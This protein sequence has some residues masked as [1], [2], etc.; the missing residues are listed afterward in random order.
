MGSTPASRTNLRSERS[1]E[2]RL[3]AEARSVKAGS[4]V[5]MFNA[6]SY[7]WQASLQDPLR[8]ERGAKGA[9]RPVR[10]SETAAGAH[11]AKAGGMPAFV[12]NEAYE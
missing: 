7:G 5:R 11:S 12:D 9:R 3:R 10:Q 8:A 4:D 1:A 2:R 6:P